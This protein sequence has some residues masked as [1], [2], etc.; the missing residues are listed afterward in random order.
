MSDGQAKCWGSNKHGQLG[1]GRTSESS[2]DRPVDVRGLPRASQLT[3]C[4]DH[5][6]ALVEGGAI[7]CWGNGEDHVLGQDDIEH[8]STPTDVPGVAGAKRIACS[9]SGGCAQ[10]ENGSIRCWGERIKAWTNF[11]GSNDV[12]GFP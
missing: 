5:T 11:P 12:P 1:T 6:C 4:W 8:R 3:A 7:K 9:M 2:S 10:F